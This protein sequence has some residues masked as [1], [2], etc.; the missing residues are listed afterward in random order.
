MHVL[1]NVRNLWPH[2]VMLYR[3]SDDADETV[4]FFVGL[5]KKGNERVAVLKTL[6]H[7]QEFEARVTGGGGI[8]RTRKGNSHTLL[9]EQRMRESKERV[10]KKER[11]KEQAARGHIPYNVR[12][13]MEEQRRRMQEGD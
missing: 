12:M 2:S 3:P 11:I 4:V 9:V 13:L 7:A 6:D 10:A 8:D 5:R 1:I